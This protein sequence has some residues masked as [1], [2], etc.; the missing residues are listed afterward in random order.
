MN[1]EAFRKIID[2]LYLDDLNVLDDIADS[3][4]L[5]DIIKLSKQYQLD[6]LFKAAEV[7]FQE[8]MQQWFETSSFLSIKN[9]SH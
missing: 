1:Y 2:Y 3:T 8:V 6:A 4:E 7:H 5:M 9:P